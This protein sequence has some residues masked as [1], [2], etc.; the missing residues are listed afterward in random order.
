MTKN[1]LMEKYHFTEAEAEDA[2]KVKTESKE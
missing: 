2:T 1:Q